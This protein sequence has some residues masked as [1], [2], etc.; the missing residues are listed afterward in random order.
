MYLSI[1]TYLCMQLFKWF[2]NLNVHTYI[3]MCNQNKLNAY[4]IMYTHIYTHTHTHIYIYIYIHTY[5]VAHSMLVNNI[6]WSMYVVYISYVNAC[7]LYKQVCIN[8]YASIVLLL[9]TTYYI[10]LLLLPLPQNH[11]G[12]LE[13][14]HWPSWILKNLSK[15]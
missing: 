2:W 5:I 4:I 15:P 12:L 9:N 1:C 10:H 11:I 7:I 8:W 14:S 6:H 3:H 13:R